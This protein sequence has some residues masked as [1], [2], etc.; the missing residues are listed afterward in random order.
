[1]T[2]KIGF[3]RT[4]REKKKKSIAESY[5]DEFRAR[6][7]QQTT[8]KTSSVAPGRVR[9]KRNW[10]AILFLC[11]WLIGWSFGIM[12]AAAILFGGDA[13][14]FIYI[15][16]IAAV[17]GWIIAFFILLGLIKGTSVDPEN[18]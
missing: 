4:D 3:S 11:V 6:K 9:R 5:L 8:V 13:P 12:L 2:R 17:I 15:W 10:V 18:D 14:F 1:M 16:I 7:S